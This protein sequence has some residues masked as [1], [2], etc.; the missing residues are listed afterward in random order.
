MRQDDFLKT[1]TYAGEQNPTSVA[2][3]LPE[4]VPKMMVLAKPQKNGQFLK[5]NFLHKGHGWVP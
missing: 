1:A 5:L 4:N 2:T 3:L